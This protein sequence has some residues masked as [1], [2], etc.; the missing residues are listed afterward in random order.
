MTTRTARCGC[1]RAEITVE[2]EP[3]LIL[4]CHCD[5][6][7]K[8]TGSVVAVSAQWPADHVVSI[9]G[10]TRCYNGLEVDGVGPA[11][12]NDAVPGGINYHFCT[13]CGSVLYWDFASRTR[14]QRTFCIGVGNFGDPGFPV[15]T[16]EYS[17]AF[18]HHWVA[19]V[20]DA[21]QF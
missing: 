10:E 2:G 4:R 13:T 6:C 12:G 18:R 3:A 20:P 21:E 11:A 5:F 7:Q 9:G 15:P 19:P 8:R 14:P 17:T 16:V 1:G